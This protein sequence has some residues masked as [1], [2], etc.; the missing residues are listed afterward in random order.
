MPDPTDLEP[1]AALVMLW[2]R[3]LYRTGSAGRFYSCLNLAAGERM[4]RECEA[5]CPWYAEVILNRK[6][7]IRHLAVG[8]V[9]EAPTPCQ[10]V[11]PAAGRSPLALELLDACNDGIASVIELDITGMEEKQRLYERAAPAHAG[12]IQCIP[13]DLSDRPATAEAIAGAG[14]NPDIPTVVIVEGISYYLPPA[15]LSGIVSLFAS[16]NRK[17]RAVVEYMLPCRLINEEQRKIPR[18][19]WRI[20][21]RDCNQGGT[22]TYSPD[23]M[24]RTLARAGCGRVVH[25]AMHEIEHARTGANHYFAAAPDGWIGIAC[26]RL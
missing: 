6:W 21:N 1:T 14:Y 13:A 26:S 19:I 22:V 8:F 5:V 23:E 10:V 3:D 12:K 18:G 15:V 9:A 17:N 20:I 16:R 24:E 2:A 7:F 11:I 4:R 25:H